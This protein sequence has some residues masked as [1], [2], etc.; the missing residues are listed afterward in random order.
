[1]PSIEI[2]I[3]AQV[4]QPQD[5]IFDLIRG[6]SLPRVEAKNIQNCFKWDYPDNAEEWDQFRKLIQENIQKLVEDE[7]IFYGHIID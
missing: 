2:A 4:P 1:M 5:L 7:F 3:K 6:T